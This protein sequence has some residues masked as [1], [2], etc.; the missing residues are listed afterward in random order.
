M[1]SILEDNGDSIKASGRNIHLG[2]VPSI[3]GLLNEKFQI[4]PTIEL[5]PQE[6]N[7]QKAIAPVE[8]AKE[9]FLPSRSEMTTQHDVLHHDEA[10]VMPPMSTIKQIEDRVSSDEYSTRS[11]VP[12][13][14]DSE[15]AHEDCKATDV[16]SIHFEQLAHLRSLLQYPSTVECITNTLFSWNRCIGY[17]KHLARPR[18]LRGHKRL[19]W[20]CVSAKH[21]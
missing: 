15:D 21:P 6:N 10:L 8:P 12:I 16:I 11:S 20:T 4:L 19:E 3:A 2:G 14:R 7:A 13:Q 5:R 1:N 18:V 17:I 9:Q